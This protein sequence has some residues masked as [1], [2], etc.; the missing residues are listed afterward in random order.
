MRYKNERLVVKMLPSD[1]AA[2]R[3]LAAA[4]GEAMAVIVRRLIREAAGRRGLWP[5]GERQQSERVEV[6]EAGDGR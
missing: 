1:K 5:P 3:R 6:Q 2:L 4:E